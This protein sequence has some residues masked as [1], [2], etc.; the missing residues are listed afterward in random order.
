VRAA[1][2]LRHRIGY[3]RWATGSGFDV[4]FGNSRIDGPIMMERPTAPRAGSARY[5]GASWMPHFPHWTKATLEQMPDSAARDRM[6]PSAGGSRAAGGLVFQAEV[7]AW[8]ASHAA[9]NS[10]PGLGLDP[11]VHV[12]AVGCETGFPVDDVGVSLN[13][14]GFILVQAKSGMR[15]LHPRAPDLRSAVDQLVGAMIK[16]LHVNGIAVRPVDVARDRLVIA[17]SHDSSQSF[18]VL[19]KVCGRLRDY[20]VSMPVLGA[21]GNEGERKALEALLGVVRSAWTAAAGRGPTDEEVRRFLRLLEVSRLDF[22]PDAGADRVRCEAML[23]RATVPRPF[24]ALVRI[25]TEAARTRTWRQRDALMAAVGMPRPGRADAGIVGSGGAQV[26]TRPVRAWDAQRLGV[27]R[28]ISADT[29]PRQA[30]PELTVYV[31]RDHDARL[32]KLLSV[33]AGPVMVVLVGGSSTGKTRAAFEAVRECLPDWSLLRPVDAADLLEQV[34]SGAARAETVLWLNETQIF[35]RGRPEVAVAL[36]QLLAQEEPIVVV[37]TMWP[38]FWK[39]LTSTPDDGGLDVNHHAR[40]LLLHDADR[41]DVRETFAGRDLAQFNRVL[42]NDPRLA[43]AAEAAHR[44]GKVVQVLA[45]GPELVQRYEHPADAED[46]FGK[47]VLTAAMD[48]RRLGFETPIGTAFLE[49]AAPAYMGPSDR[50]DAPGTWFTA[51]LGHATREIRGIAALTGQRQGPVIGPPD[52][53]VLHDYL[54]Q[55][56]RL[57]RRGVLIPAMV[58]DALTAH[59]RDPADRTRLAQQAERRGLYRYAVDLARPAAEAGEATAMALMARRLAG[60]GHSDE[61]E[62]W[63]RRAAEAGDPVAVHRLVKHL[64]EEGDHDGA[65]T[66]LRTAAAVGDTSALLSLVARLDESGQAEEAERLLVQAAE[67]GDTVV[68]ERLATRLDEAGRPDDAEGWLRRAA[69]SGDIIAMQQLAGRLDEAGKAEEAERWLAQAAEMDD[70]FAHFVRGRLYQRLEEAGRPDEAEAWLR[71]DIEDGDTSYLVILASRLDQAGH[72][73]EAAEL[74]QRARDAGEWLVLHPAIEEIKQAGGGLEDFERLL[75]G[76]AEAGDLF[77]MQS[78]AT[79]FDEAGRGPEANQWLAEM[80]KTGNLHALHVLVGRLEVA[81]RREEA[82]QV[83]RWI[84]EAGSSVGVERL[85][86][87]LEETDP[88]A[89]ESLRRYGIEPGGT[90]AAPW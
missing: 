42:A 73:E 63:T 82:V 58:W 24:S 33:P 45:G 89:A 90:T 64:D 5:R 87:H 14:G 49:A 4:L 41:V 84:L 62:E 74:R 81:N 60:A 75:R 71:R 79:Q 78:L 77:S 40:E 8:W 53:Y 15:Q 28:A 51:G 50:A 47:A 26:G 31:Q 2:D 55:H 48:A 22:E 35:L 6:N 80:A 56:G 16:G 25:G 38:E 11:A 59:V 57:T 20:P 52:G 13:S 70:H 83:W 43:T 66:I 72:A 34:R 88:A 10:A 9:S 21:A 68:M 61:A 19:G 1:S 44:D 86:P 37:G 3:E 65:E 23:E 76:P 27:H 46:R 18:Q 54:D 29:T 85:A 69:K 39:E 12:D 32:R 67:A 30:V 17:T 36:R 7:F